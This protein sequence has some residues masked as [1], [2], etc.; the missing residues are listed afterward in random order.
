L[1]N[2]LER[3]ETKGARGT[4]LYVLEQLRAEVPLMVLASIIVEDSY[5]AREEALSLIGRGL[6]EGSPADFA[7]AEATLEGARVSADPE[8]AQ[9][10][11]RALKYLRTKG[12][13]TLRQRRRDGATP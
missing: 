7:E 12:D 4:L 8:R 2:L 10:I 9:A 11:G 6:I 1:V 5:E 13:A 3:R